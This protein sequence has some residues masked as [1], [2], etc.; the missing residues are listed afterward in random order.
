MNIYEQMARKFL[1]SNPDLQKNP[2]IANAIGC[3]EKGDTSGAKQ[4]ASNFG[5]QMG[6]D[7]QKMYNQYAQRLR[8]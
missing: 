4:I 5:G 8:R 1:A 2:I 3:A 7:V 6:A